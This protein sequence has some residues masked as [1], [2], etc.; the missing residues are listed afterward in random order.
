VEAFQGSNRDED[1]IGTCTAPRFAKRA[2][3]RSTTRP[4]A[5]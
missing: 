2:Q 1:S 3:L 5:Q 4:F